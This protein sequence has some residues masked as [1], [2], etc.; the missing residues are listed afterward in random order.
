MCW[1]HCRICTLLEERNR[2][3]AFVVY[4][5]FKE[6]T[7]KDTY[8]LEFRQQIDKKDRRREGSQRGRSSLTNVTKRMK[9]S[10]LV[11]VS[12]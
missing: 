5:P 7:L 9:T 4:A 1:A 8:K 2:D 11:S 6:F 12:G 10:I 3:K